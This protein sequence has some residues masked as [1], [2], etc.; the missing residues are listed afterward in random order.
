MLLD[1]GRD[2]GLTMGDQVT[3]GPELLIIG[4][5]CQTSPKSVQESH[6]A[7]IKPLFWVPP[8]SNV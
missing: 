6:L 5:F 3:S 2:R 4:G 8:T 7:K 1:L